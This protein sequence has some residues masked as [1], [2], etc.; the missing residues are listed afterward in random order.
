[1]NFPELTLL[2]KLRKDWKKKM[3]G[4]NSTKASSIPLKKKVPTSNFG[5]SSNH[6]CLH[7]QLSHSD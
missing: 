4:G 3:L 7:L 1:M 2:Y 6:I 5:A